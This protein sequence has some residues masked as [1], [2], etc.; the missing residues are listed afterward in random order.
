MATNSDPYPVNFEEWPRHDQLLHV[1]GRYRRGRL[2]EKLLLAAGRD[3]DDYGLDDDRKLSKQDIAS[4]YLALG[5]AER[6]RYPERFHRLD[7]AAQA[8]FVADRFYRDGLLAEVLSLAGRDTDD[9]ELHSDS[10]LTKNDLAAI[11]LTVEGI[12]HDG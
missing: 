8:A 6:E 7:P 3:C 12:S 9:R 2:I 10:K 5:G 4:L 1:A 11:Y